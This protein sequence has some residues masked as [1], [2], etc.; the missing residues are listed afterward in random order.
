MNEFALSSH[1][2]G[3]ITLKSLHFELGL[4]LSDLLVPLNVR[5]GVRVESSASEDASFILLLL[6]DGLK[7][8]LDHLECSLF[9]V[10]L[11]HEL[12]LLFHEPG[13][14][15]HPLVVAIKLLLNGAR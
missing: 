3:Q 11:L 8:L 5:E 4:S 10:A 6:D 9:S 2:F 12:L 14:G 15:V 1:E 7:L 13:G